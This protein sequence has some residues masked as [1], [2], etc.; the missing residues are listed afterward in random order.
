MIKFLSNQRERE[1]ERERER[2]TETD[3][4]R[5]RQTKRQRE[6]YPY[7][8]C[9]LKLDCLILKTF[10]CEFPSLFLTKNEN[11]LWWWWLC[12]R[13]K[14]MMKTILQSC[15]IV[16]WFVGI[17]R[18][19]VGIFTFAN[20]VAVLKISWKSFSLECHFLS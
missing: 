20:S 12:P 19:Y 16:N 9:I 18:Y 7:Y 4:G 6:K 1:R 17:D 15:N 3:R 10:K 2:Q 14:T 8:V 11:G 5:D 13:E